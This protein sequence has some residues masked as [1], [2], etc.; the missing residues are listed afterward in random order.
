MH[1]PTGSLVVL[2]L[3]GACHP[4]TPGAPSPTA[5]DP[6]AVVAEADRLATQELWPGFQPQTIP[7]AIYDGARTLLFRHPAPPEEFL[8]LAGSESTRFLVGRH[9]QV[10]ANSTT[11]LGGVLTATVMPSA[12]GTSLRS[13]AALVL[14]EAFH[15]FQRGRHPRWVANE[16]ELFTYPVS[17]PELL[18]LRRLETEALRRALAARGELETRCWVRTATT[19]RQRRFAAMPAGSVAYERLNEL[20]EGLATYI[21]RR[22]AGAPDTGTLPAVPYAPEAVRQRTYRSG[23]ALGVLLDRV[24]GDWQET[25]ERNDSIPLDILLADAVAIERADEP[26]CEVPDPERQRIQATAAADAHGLRT[27]LAVE[28]RAFLDQPG[29][30]VVIDARASVLFPQRFDPLNVQVVATGEVL[31]GRHLILGNDLGTIEVLGR[32]S[33]TV[34]AGAHPLFNGASRLVIS[35]L[36]A[37]PTV[38]AAGDIVRI[39]APGVSGEWRGGIVEHVGQVVTIRLPGGA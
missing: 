20:N 13:R 23:A 18:A 39:T 28:R 4:V 9:P 15:V 24:A 11:E 36:P 7:V 8:P 16:V 19:I 33:L 37:A 22:A 6:V 17:D 27:R 31:H 3:L 26:A 5:P 38:Q 34:S 30:Q 29:W 1:P 2:M 14:H 25:L 12:P 32:P 35:G 21:E 10:T